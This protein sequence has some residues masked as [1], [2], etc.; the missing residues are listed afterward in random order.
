MDCQSIFWASG[1][2]RTSGIYFTW[3]A[4]LVSA[5]MFTEFQPKFFPKL[6]PGVGANHKNQFSY[7]VCQIPGEISALN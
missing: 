4:S 7:P 2:C 3:T 5:Y 1:H 6:F